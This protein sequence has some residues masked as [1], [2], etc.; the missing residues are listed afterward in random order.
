M[1]ELHIT[2]SLRK[3]E[4]SYGLLVQAHVPAHF[5]TLLGLGLLETLVIVRF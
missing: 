2:V 3:S 1:H 4:V 5:N